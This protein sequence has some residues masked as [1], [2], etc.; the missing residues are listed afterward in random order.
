MIAIILFSLTSDAINSLAR[1]HIGKWRT[2]NRLARLFTV[3]LISA[4]LLALPAVA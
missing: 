3:A 1:L 4:G 2:P